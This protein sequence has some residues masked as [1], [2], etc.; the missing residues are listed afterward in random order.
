MKQ[1]PFKF[2]DAYEKQDKDI[3][4]GRETEVDALYQMTYQTNLMLV[5]GMSGTG[6]TSLIQC[7]LANCFESSDWFAIPIR[8]Q[9]NINSA[10]VRELRSKDAEESFEADFTLPQMVHSLYLDYLRPIYLIFD[11]FEELYILGN[12]AEQE[13]FIQTVREILLVEQPVKIIL[14]IREEYLGHLYEF[15]RAVPELLRKKL[16]VEP[17]NL[18]K[19]KTVIEGVGRLP[20]SNV[21]L[22]A[23]EEH[24]IA[25]GIFDKIRGEEKTLSIQLPYLQVFLD[26]LYLQT[27]GDETRE[28][29]AVFTSAALAGMGDIGDV[30]RNFLDE[31]VLL[32]AQKLEQKPE[33]IWRILSPFVTLEGTKEPL[34]EQVLCERLPDVLPALVGSTL[35]AFVSSRILRYT[36]HEQRYEIAHDSLAKQIH[37]KRS[38]E[39]IAILEVQRLVHSQVALKAEAREFFTEKQ[40][41]FIEPYLSKFT[42]G[43]EELDWIARSRVYVQEEAR[44]IQQENE[45][46]LAAAERQAEKERTLRESAEAAKTEAVTAK[47]EAE[48]NEKRARQR[49]RIAAVAFALALG[50]AIIAGWSYVRANHSAELAQEQKTLAEKKTQETAD[51]LKKV[52]QEKTAT[53]EQRSIA[54]HK[55]REAESNFQRAE[56]NLKKAQAEENRAKAALLQVKREQNATEEQRRIAEQNFKD[57]K[58]ATTKAEQEQNK[59]KETLQKLQKTNED[60]VLRFLQNARKDMSGGRYEDALEKIKTAEELKVLKEEVCNAY[61]EIA[62]SSLLH[63][64]FEVALKSVKAAATFG[65]L[66]SDAI[67]KD[68][69]DVAQKSIL[70]LEYEVALESAKAAATLGVPKPEVSGIYLEIAFWHGEAGNSRRATGILDSAALLLDKKIDTNQPHRKAIEVFDPAVYKKMMER[71]YP[72]MVQVEGGTFDM[73]CDPGEK[74]EDLHKQEVSAFQ[75]AKYETTWWQYA[76][77]CK[78][79]GNEYSSPG[80]GTEGHNPAVNVSWYDAVAY[81]NWVSKQLGKKEV[82]AKNAD[83]KYSVT[84]RTGYRLP[85]EAEWEYG[86]KGGNRPEGKIYS[87]NNELDSVG[88]FN[89]NSG[90]RTRAV[91][92][93]QANALGLY[94]MSGNVWEWCWDWYSDYPKKLK[95]DYDGT[96][97]GSDRVLRGGSWDSSAGYCR[98][99]YRGGGDP[100]DRDNSLGFRLVFVP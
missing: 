45:E 57:A 95:K 40:L 5:Y 30:L 39:E 61:L 88:W 69:L 73:G 79:T 9:E 32:T 80:W 55:T 24:A 76:L 59:S 13:R 74:C 89:G 99:A 33:S 17:M 94:D 90:R 18:D 86:A 52:E 27:T 100:D 68:Y 81:C 36:E 49:T 56:E 4:F 35:Q 12:K 34:S 65:I 82:I 51:A 72:V 42:A 8:R 23:G 93:K 38:D 98:T 58:L 11:Q 22:Q 96:P 29:D 10:L 91:G 84:L 44:R 46:K 62:D 54:Q 66:P 78:A 64:E 85:T 70:H 47:T 20:Q 60:F 7:G 21:R 71:Y 67:G 14:S 77:F 43:E 2:L 48:A 50:L 28:A 16:R 19:V 75:M 41:A 1:S 53:E 92:K 87:G 25:E 63:N 37:A 31:Q 3:F 83:G 15:E 26:K 97:E 6:K